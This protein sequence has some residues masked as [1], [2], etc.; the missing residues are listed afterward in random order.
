[1]KR[2]CSGNVYAE[3]T[4]PSTAS[5]QMVT[6]EVLQD[7]IEG[8]KTKFQHLSEG[9][10]AVQ[11]ESEKFS[12]HID[13]L[14]RDSHAHKGAQE[15]RIQEMQEGLVRFLDR[16]DPAHLAASARTFKSPC[17]PVM[18]T[19]F[20]QSG[21]PSRRCPDFDCESPVN[22]TTPTESTRNSRNHHYNERPTHED[23]Q[24]NNGDA[25]HSSNNSG[26][27]NSGSHPSLRPKV[28]IFYGTVSTQFRPWIIQFEAIARHQ[29]WTMGERVVR[30]VSSLTGPAANMLIGMSMGQLDDYAFLVAHL[31]R[32]YDPPEGEEAYR[33][34]LRA[35]TRR[36]NETA[37]EFAENLKNLAQRAYT[38][39][40]QN[41]LDN[42]VVERFR[43]GHSNEELKKHSCLYPSTGLQDL[44]GACVRFETH[45]EIG[46]RAHKSN[47]GLYTVQGSNPSELSLEEVT[48]ATRKLG[49]TLRPW[50]DR[51]QGNRIFNNNG[52]SRYQNRGE[53]QQGSRFNQN[54]NSGARPQNP[55]RKQTPIGEVKCWTCGKTGHYVLDCK[56]NGPKFAFAPKVIR[57]N[58]LQEI[59]DQE[60]DY[61]EGEQNNSMGND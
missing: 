17:A 34:E 29:C 27:N 44:I 15:R 1:M 49:F 53:P 59:S 40:D 48:R 32:R 13:N 37:D 33:A 10:S 11:L 36:R 6:T 21:A 41:M 23:D 19:P 61:S 35:R 16:C 2:W 18:S 14:Q 9:I 12:A 58:Y 56:T 3:E 22:R 60:N 57:M 39:A 43:E 24:G 46:A 30:L 52:P 4:T 26:M 20:T 55:I 8:W 25:Q 50:V 38:N 42:L 7:I 5:S 28:P 54:R 47:E 31:S 51:Q 45:V